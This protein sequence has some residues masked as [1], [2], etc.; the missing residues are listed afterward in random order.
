MT[1]AAR[2]LE[3]TPDSSYQSRV[4]LAAAHRLANRFGFD[5]G[6]HNH[7]TLMVPDTTNQFLVKAHGLLM[8]EITA[9]NLI[10]ADTEGNVIEGSGTI[11]R[12]AFCIHA[13][14]H[15]RHPAT[16][17][18]LH[19]HPP[20]S[21]WLADVE[22]GHLYMTNQD[23]LRFHE[24]IAYDD[25]YAGADNE[26]GDQF[27]SAIGGKSVLISRNHGVTVVGATVAEAF[28][29]LYYLELACKRQYLLATSGCK[30]SVVPENISARTRQLSD[31]E[32]AASAALY[33]E[34]LKREL[35]REDPR[36]TA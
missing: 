34:A 1:L 12:S 32:F 9:N 4:D 20:Y 2:T 35:D 36:Y 15:V 7:F 23:I 26:V 5:D 17:C 29:D 24:R 22:D 3:S 14:I 10:V 19:A 13:A 8:S 6:I 28:Y 21:T 31:S 16:K 18:I 27:A 33:F 25:G 30:A 11:E